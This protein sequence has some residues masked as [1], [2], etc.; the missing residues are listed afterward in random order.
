MEAIRQREAEHFPDKINLYVPKMHYHSDI[1]GPGL[2]RIN[3][4]KPIAADD[5]GILAAQDIAVA[6]ITY[7]KDFAA[8][9][10]ADKMGKYGRNVTVVASGTATSLVHVRGTDYLGQPMLETFTLSG[11]DVRVGLKAFK[12]VQ[13][14]EFGATSSRTIN[15]GWGVRLGLP[16]AA[17][18]HSATFRDG[19]AATLTARIATDPQTATTGDPRG[20]YSFADAPNG[21][22]EFDIAYYADRENLHGVAHYHA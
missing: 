9:Y 4:G 10:H 15:V 16:F 12:K 13:S 19:G 18:V 11:T 2:V 1:E 5:D 17:L 8:T 21:T 20:T 6:G 22:R 14:I 3:L 7:A